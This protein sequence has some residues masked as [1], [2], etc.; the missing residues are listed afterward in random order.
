MAFTQAGDGTHLHFDVSG[1]RDGEPVLL[2]QGLGADGRG[3]AL[4]RRS[5]GAEHR[6]IVFDNRG[7]G[8]SD[9]PDGPYDLE[10]MA[11]DALAVLEAAGYQSAHVMGASMGGVIAQ[12]LAVRHPERVRSLILACTAC[13]HR[14]WRRELLAGWADLAL[15][16]G[17]GAF[18]RVNLKWL[19][20]ARSRRRFALPFNVV[21]PFALQVS[22]HAFAAQVDAILAMDDALA[23]ELTRL[24]V[25]TLVI[26]GSQDVLT[27]RGDSEELAS[28]IPGAELVVVPGAAHGLMVEHAPAF[29]RAVVSF[30]RNAAASGDVGGERRRAG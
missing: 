6:A 25:P 8:R 1:R 19:V 22:P 28:R 23:G 4:Q 9:E 30:L 16:R 24:R 15:A 12:I 10:V 26:V 11:G 17:M 18:T 20:G 27:P 14:P 29:N 5:I 13:R 3:W 7:T 2:I 21:G